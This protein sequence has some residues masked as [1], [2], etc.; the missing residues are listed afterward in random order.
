[1]F[2]VGQKIVCVKSFEYLR[3]DWGYNYPKVNDI[4]EVLSIRKHHT[5]DDYLIRISG[6]ECEV[7]ASY[8]KPLQRRE[9]H[10]DVEEFNIACS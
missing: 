3:F 9:L 6:L 7:C 8:F 10:C 4:V 5:I 1:M 2:S